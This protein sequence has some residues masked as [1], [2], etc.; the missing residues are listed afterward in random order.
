M[1]NC[2][3]NKSQDSKPTCFV[4]YADGTEVFIHL[5]TDV[6]SVQLSCCPFQYSTLDDTSKI[7]DCLLFCG[8][9]VTAGLPERI[10]V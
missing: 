2:E 7:F 4:L 5:S 8:F 3:L 9:D 10:R 6:I 1:V